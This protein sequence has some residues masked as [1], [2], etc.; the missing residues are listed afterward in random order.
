MKSAEHDF[1]ANIVIIYLSV[2][3]K[4]SVFGW[5]FVSQTK[6]IPLYSDI[7]KR[8][9]HALPDREGRNSKSE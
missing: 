3:F 5:I 7:T 2:C 8:K 6:T 1:T 9:T 4:G